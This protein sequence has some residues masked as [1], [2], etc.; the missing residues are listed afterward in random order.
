MVSMAVLLLMAAC[1]L[2]MAA[3]SANSV[4]GNALYG[5]Q[6]DFEELRLA[7]TRYPSARLE[8]EL[9]LRPAATG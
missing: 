3:L 5:V 9:M 2:A 4:P 8:V 6:R 7:L 1:G